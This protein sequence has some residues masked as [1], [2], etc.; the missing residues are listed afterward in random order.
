MYWW[1]WLIFVGLAFMVGV[2]VGML[3]HSEYAKGDEA[4]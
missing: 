1:L 4:S 3:L 2:G